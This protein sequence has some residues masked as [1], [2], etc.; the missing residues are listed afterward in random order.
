[1]LLLKTNNK[2]MTETLDTSHSVYVYLFAAAAAGDWVNVVQ[3]VVQIY[4]YV[5]KV[6]VVSNNAKI[7]YE[8]RQHRVA[9]KK[10]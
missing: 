4:L 5:L 2:L 6:S 9:V 10:W 3:L 8:L 1:M 7:R